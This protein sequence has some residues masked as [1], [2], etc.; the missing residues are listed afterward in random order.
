[1]AP[2]A[3][4]K[5]ALEFEFEPKHVDVRQRQTEVQA[6]ERLVRFQDHVFEPEQ[7]LSPRSTRAGRR[8]R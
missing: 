2:L 6:V 4:D 5:E 1:M 7:P 3:R 8:C